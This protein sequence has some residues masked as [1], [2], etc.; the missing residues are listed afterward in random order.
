M[1][2]DHSFFS[3]QRTLYSSR[4]SAF[5]HEPDENNVLI[6]NISHVSRLIVDCLPPLR[7]PI[8][9][10]SASSLC[11]RTS[12]RWVASSPGGRANTNCSAS[13]WPPRNASRTRCSSRCARR[14]RTLAPLGWGS[15]ASH[16]LGAQTHMG[17]NHCNSHS[18]SDT[19]KSKMHQFLSECLPSS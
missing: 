15:E 19:A 17:V 3:V 13:G 10:A 11:T 6:M 5:L 2:N 12:R 14:Y 18:F 7:A 1:C 16:W 4:V 8:R 9:S